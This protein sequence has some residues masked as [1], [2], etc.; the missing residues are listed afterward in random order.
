[1]TTTAATTQQGR[2][3]HFGVADNVRA[4]LA[5]QRWSGRAA[6]KE[7]GWSTPYLQR[8]LGG[9]QPFDVADLLTLSRLLN[10]PVTRFFAG[11]KPVSPADYK[12]AVVRDRASSAQR[13]RK[14]KT[15]P[16]NRT[17]QRRSRGRGE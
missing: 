11:V 12:A 5:R 6:A 13:P 4:E 3:G 7:V 9:D 8:R 2:D 14:P 15:R 17:D 16:E 10:V 1:M